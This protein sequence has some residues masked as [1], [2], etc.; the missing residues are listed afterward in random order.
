MFTFI[1]LEID[2]WGEKNC[3]IPSFFKLARPLPTVLQNTQSIPRNVMLKLSEEFNSICQ[4][5]ISPAI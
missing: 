4:Q 5:K 1:Y 2:S 3:A